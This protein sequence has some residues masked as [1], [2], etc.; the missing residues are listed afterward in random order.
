[1]CKLS[2]AGPKREGKPGLS[3][4]EALASIAVVAIITGISI[5]AILFIL[6]RGEESAARRG[7]LAVA[8]LASSATAAGNTEISNAVD[9]EAA[10]ELLTY[11]VTGEGQ[12]SDSVFVVNIDQ[13]N[14]KQTLKFLSFRDGKLEFDGPL[15]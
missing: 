11:G 6:Q 8:G 9:K 10:L 12:F 2:K 13:K 15:E 7:A 14:R 5:P 4:R 3:L 1:M